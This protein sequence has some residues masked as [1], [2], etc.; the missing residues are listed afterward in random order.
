MQHYFKNNKTRQKNWKVNQRTIATRMSSMKRAA[1]FLLK[2]DKLVIGK[3][4]V[5]GEGFEWS[6]GPHHVFGGNKGPTVTLCGSCHKVFDKQGGI[7]E[8]KA[9]RKKYLKFNK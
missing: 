9:R 6:L 4:V 2:W 7:K 1:P 5:C 3:C 8:L